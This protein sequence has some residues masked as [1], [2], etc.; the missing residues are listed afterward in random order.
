MRK[1]I[2]ALVALAG[3]ASTP[4][5]LKRQVDYDAWRGVP[6]IELETQ[7]HFAA[8]RRIV[9]PLS[10]GSELWVYSHCFTESE[11]VRCVSSD[12]SGTILTRC[13]GGNQSTS[14]CYNQFLVRDG[15][16]ESYRL[17]GPCR[18]GCDGR[19]ASSPCNDH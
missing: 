5:G 15:R 3:C 13:R 16:V 17:E 4:R 8:E 1:A 7:P 12:F 9:R 14:C 19:P 6:I 2:V 11:D 10:D 18:T